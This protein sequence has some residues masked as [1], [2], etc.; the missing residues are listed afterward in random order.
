MMIA[1]TAITPHMMNST[2]FGGIVIAA[3]LTL[4]RGVLARKAECG[5]ICDDERVVGIHMIDP[6]EILQGFAVSDGACGV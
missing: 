2:R 1:T 4:P 3:G 5:G 6:D